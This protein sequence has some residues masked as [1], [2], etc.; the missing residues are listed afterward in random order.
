MR[1][2]AILGA[3]EGASL[4]PRFTPER[5]VDIPVRDRL[6]LTLC[7]AVRR[8]VKDARPGRRHYRIDLGSNTEIYDSGVAMLLLLD[9]WASRDSDIELVNCPL[10]LRSRLQ[11]LGLRHRFLVS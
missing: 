9:E 5:C 11:H 8:A 10:A 6:D 1:G 7:T 2:D 3:T 4:S